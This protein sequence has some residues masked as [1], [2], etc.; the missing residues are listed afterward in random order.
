MASPAINADMTLSD[1]LMLF[2]LAFIWGG[3]FFFVG[4]ALKE[5][6]PLTIVLLRVGVAALVLWSVLIVRGIPIPRNPAIWLAFLTMGV[7]NNVIP[8]TLIVWGQQHIASGLAAIFNGTVPMFTV[9]LATFLLNDEKINR[10]KIVGIVI[11]FIGVLIMF[12]PA[13]DN[14]AQLSLL[15]QLAILGAALSYGFAGIFG[16]RFRE[17]KVTPMMTAT[18]QVT[19]SALI[20]LPITLIIEQP[21]SLPAPSIITWLCV[22]SLAAICTA[23]AYILYF[24]ILASAGATNL[25]LV[26]LLVPVSAIVLGA[27]FLEEALSP[28]HYL[29]MACIGAGLLVMDG[30][31]WRRFTTR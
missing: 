9:I 4:V 16:R 27:L 11:G 17:L 31:L 24:K 14:S 18:G 19:G 29:G 3:S 13:I 12:S 6:P 20:L 1:W 8:F 5:L 10:Q 15:G 7:L 2:L 21:F 30:R 22:L 28:I 25:S 26:T 23:F